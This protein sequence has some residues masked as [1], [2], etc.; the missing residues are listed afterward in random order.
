MRLNGGWF[1]PFT[2]RSFSALYQRTTWLAENPILLNFLLN[3]V[4]CFQPELVNASHSSVD[5]RSKSENGN[6][7]SIVDSVWEVQTKVF[8]MISEIY[9]RVGNIL[10]VNRWLSAV[11][12][13]MLFLCGVIEYIYIYTWNSDW[14][15]SVLKIGLSENNGCPGSQGL[16]SGRQ[17]SGQVS[18]CPSI[19]NKPYL[20]Y[21]FELAN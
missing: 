19:S 17:Y 21:N 18:Y 15:V 2:P 14:N 12:V 4:A 8:T 6:R 9:L 1:L 11:V 10:P 13:I 16:P 20:R 5:W 7:A 3:I